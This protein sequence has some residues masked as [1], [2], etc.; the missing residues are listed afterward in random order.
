MEDNL[1]WILHFFP[2][3]G[4]V[5]EHPYISLVMLVVLQI[6]LLIYKMVGIWKVHIHI[7]QFG[8]SISS[9]PMSLAKA[10][11]SIIGVHLLHFV[12]YLKEYE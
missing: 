8:T 11:M 10:T 5:N 6:S 1:P 3:S 7:V 9:I 2:R 12:V 4:L